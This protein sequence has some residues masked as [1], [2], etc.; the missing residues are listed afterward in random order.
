MYTAGA[1][2]SVASCAALKAGG[3]GYGEGAG[4]ESGNSRTRSGASVIQPSF[5]A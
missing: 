3:D 2:V 5:T 1:G 4:E